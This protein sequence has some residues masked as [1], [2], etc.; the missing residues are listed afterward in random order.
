MEKIN[1]IIA[2]AYSNNALIDSTKEETV[3]QCVV[4]SGKISQKDSIFPVSMKSLRL[5]ELPCC[6]EDMEIKGYCKPLKTPVFTEIYVPSMKLSQEESDDILKR[7]SNLLMKNMGQQS[8]KLKIGDTLSITRTFDDPTEGLS[9]VDTD[10]VLREIKDGK[11]YFNIRTTL[12]AEISPMTGGGIGS[13]T[14][15]YDIANY[16][17]L[18]DNIFIET[19]F[20]YTDENSLIVMKINA[21]TS[22][23][24]AVED[25]T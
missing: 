13:G 1:T 25:N 3:S 15:V 6:V 17:F 5:D 2:K 7:M 9:K 21:D 19:I 18:S 11:A 14:A 23:T 20:T 22:Q 10:Y 12:T 16:T 8:K 4:T 24:V